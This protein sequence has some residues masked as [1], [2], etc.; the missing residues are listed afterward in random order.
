M[1]REY[2]D[3]KQVVEDLRKIHNIKIAERLN[4]NNNLVM[5]WKRNEIQK[6]KNF[7]GYTYEDLEEEEEYYENIGLDINELNCLMEMK[8]MFEEKEIDV[9]NEEYQDEHWRKLYNIGYIYMDRGDIER[10]LIYYKQSLDLNEK[11]NGVGHFETAGTI[12]NIGSVYR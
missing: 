8:R 12:M 11:V 1:R 10:A 2:K 6:N 4:D 5:N 3:Y 9:N 7:S